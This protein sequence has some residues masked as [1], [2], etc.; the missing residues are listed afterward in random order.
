[1]NRKSLLRGVSGVYAAL[2]FVFLYAPIAVL[3]ALSFNESKLRNSW[4][5]FS[6]KWYASL[7]QNDRII[8]ALGNTLLISFS[9]ALVATMIGTLAAIALHNM[10]SGAA[11][12]L[13]L[14]VTYIPMLNPDI[15][16]GVAL[17]LLF[18]FA[19]ITLGFGTLLLAHIAFNIPYVV[20][21]VLP[22]LKQLNPYTMDAAMDLGMRPVGALW[23]VII[24]QIFPG[25][26][27]GFLLALTMS[28]DDFAISFFTTGP[29]VSTLSI[30]IYSMTRRGINP[31]IN[32]L[33]TLMFV[34]V[35][36]MLIF[37]NFR[38]DKDNGQMI[39]IG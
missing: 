26:M 19:G 8:Q 2:I 23:K 12:T 14:D 33:S 5:G 10:K 29:G 38:S 30:E 35:L 25:M 36:A 21:S 27:T 7:F 17:L 1:M 20:L 32:A 31:Q 6:L 34:V 13:L 22:K 37:V 4:G 39:N 9:A 28:I 24:P 3:I 15:V 18:T 16:T 11:R